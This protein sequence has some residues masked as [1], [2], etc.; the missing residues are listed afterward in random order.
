MHIIRHLHLIQALS[1]F[2]CIFAGSRGRAFIV[3]FTRNIAP[4]IKSI[5]VT[6]E[7]GTQ[8]NISTSPNLDSWIKNQTDK[9]LV[10]PSNKRFL[11]PT[12]MELLSFKKEVKSI[13][14]ETSEDAFIIS[15][16]EFENGY[17]VGS[18][19]HI[20]LRKLSTSYVVITTDPE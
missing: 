13:W 9:S 7:N 6:S 3:L 15:R 11:I 8:I 19:T 4:S 18:T 17:S 1:G 2:L 10:I 20:P 12:D 16:D 14:I 5:Y